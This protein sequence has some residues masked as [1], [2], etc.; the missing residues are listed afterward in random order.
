M[1]KSVEHTLY[2]V[3]IKVYITLRRE[4]TSL[5]PWF[6]FSMSKHVTSVFS[7]F[8]KGGGTDGGAEVG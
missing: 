4:F 7:V 5:R 8:V 1:V 2:I 3:V 6:I